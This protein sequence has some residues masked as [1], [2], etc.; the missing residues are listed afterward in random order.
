[1]PTYV[2]P[3]DAVPVDALRLNEDAFA[4]KHAI[5]IL[6]TIDPSNVDDSKRGDTVWLCIQKLKACQRY[7][8]Q[9]LRTEF[10]DPRKKRFERK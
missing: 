9:K 4:L 6:K 10:L 5:L 8:N 1:M 3:R 7:A 2:M